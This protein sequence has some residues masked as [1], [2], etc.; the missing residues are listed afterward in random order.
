MILGGSWCE[1]THISRRFSSIFIFSLISAA[2]QYKGRKGNCRDMSWHVFDTSS[3]KISSFIFIL[4]FLFYFNSLSL[5]LALQSYVVLFHARVS[6]RTSE[7]MQIGRD[8][9]AILV[10]WKGFEGYE[11]FLTRA[12]IIISLSLSFSLSLSLS[13]SLSFKD[14]YN[15]L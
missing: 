1:L 11:G 4:S 13:L 5:A 14:I 8:G 6:S 12:L 15:Y 7:L 2:W 3:L 9:R 10:N